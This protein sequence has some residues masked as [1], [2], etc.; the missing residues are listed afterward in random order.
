MLGFCGKEVLLFCCG[1]MTVVRC[2]LS[3]CFYLARFVFL[4]RMIVW[5]VFSQWLSIGDLC[6]SFCSA[7]LRK[8]NNYEWWAL[9]FPLFFRVCFLYLWNL[10]IKMR[11]QNRLLHQIL[12]SQVEYFCC[13]FNYCVP[14]LV[15]YL[16]YFTIE[17]N[18]CLGRLMFILFACAYCLDRLLFFPCRETLQCFTTFFS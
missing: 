13:T 10:F 5:R 1:I 18:Y 16:H 9:M 14:E 6:K 17:L 4:S 3:V 15:T 11:C 7:T 2:L 12:I 8:V